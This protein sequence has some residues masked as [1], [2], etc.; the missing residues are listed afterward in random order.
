MHRTLDFPSL[1]DLRARF[2]DVHELAYGYSNPNDVIEVVN[3]RL[4]AFARIRTERSRGQPDN[5]NSPPTPVGHRPVWFA[6]DTAADT[7][8]YARENLRPGQCIPGPAVIEQ[9]DATTLVYPDDAARLDPAG[10]IVI[11][12]DP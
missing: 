3:A 6:T 12:L 4:T 9:L 11:D 5:H 2:L 10:N 8:V 7:P 1:L